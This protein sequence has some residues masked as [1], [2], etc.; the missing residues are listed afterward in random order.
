MADPKRQ[1]NIRET[2]EV[3]LGA[4]GIP[5]G[6]LHF[7]THGRREISQFAYD[8][9]WLSHPYRFEISPDLPLVSGYQLRR[10]A[11]PH[12][13]VFHFALAD[14]AP[15]SWGRRVMMR[16]HAKARQENRDIAPLNELDFLC[17]VDD[18]S[19]VGALRLCTAGQYLRTVDAGR[20]TTLVFVEL[21]KMY[22]ATRAV[23][24]HQETRE[25][26][27]YL[28]GK[29]TSLG[30]MR[31]K[32]TVLDENGKLA[33]GK[34]PSIGDTLDVTR[35]E[36]LAMRLARQAGIRTAT[37]R[38]VT[39]N[40][41]AVAIIERFDRTDAGG[42]IPY[43]S[44]ASMLQAPRDA[45]LSYADLVDVIRQRCQDP[46]SDARELWRRL[47][48]NLLVTNTDDHLHNHGFL[49]AGNGQW[50]LSPAFDL[51]PMPGKLRESKTWLTEDSGPIE[52]IDM[53]LA[54]CAY[55]SLTHRQGLDIVSEVLDAVSRWR[56]V[57]QSADIGLGK[58]E[59]ADFDDAFEHEQIDRARRALSS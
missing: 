44:A 23:E 36:V 27:Q 18:F 11:G 39:I 7:V 15:D 20:R 59:L 16:A 52:T 6:T 25:D 17:A 43:L 38:C 55:F 56:H 13:S 54:Q 32:C 19:R 50:R 5:V 10:A 28:M 1:S 51:N 21:E 35:A 29:A 8:A 58:H 53:L 30:G 24:A 49:Y 26:L 48:F 12:D 9:S 34:F 37:A 45:Q 3:H 47:A 33:L 57:A 2:V 42:R 22:Q 41:T 4:E 31:P 46:D 14:T 40:D